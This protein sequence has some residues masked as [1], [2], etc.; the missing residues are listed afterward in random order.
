MHH[1]TLSNT[2]RNFCADTPARAQ[3]STPLSIRPSLRSPREHRT[4]LENPKKGLNRSYKPLRTRNAVQ[5]TEFPRTLE[6]TVQVLVAI[7]SP[8]TKSALHTPY[9][10]LFDST[11]SDPFH[12]SGG[13]IATQKDAGSS[14]SARPAPRRP[15][16]GGTPP[17]LAAG[18]CGVQKSQS[19]RRRHF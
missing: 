6:N 16:S 8:G 7:Y 12:P 18:R 1:W 10:T 3:Y 5:H 14:R 17:C 11:E 4:P 13:M 9:E 15:R 2:S 19:N